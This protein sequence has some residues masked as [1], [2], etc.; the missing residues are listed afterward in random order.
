MQLAGR[1]EEVDVHGLG[2]RPVRRSAHQHRSATAASRRRAAPSASCKDLPWDLVGS[3]TA[4][5]VERAPRAPELLSRGVHE[6][7]ETFDIGNPNLQIE[8]AKTVEAGIRRAARAS[9][10]SRR[11]PTTPAIRGFI[12]RNLTGETCDGTSIPA[13]ARRSS[14]PAAN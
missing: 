6:A 1:I 4:Q 11:P 2:A 9:S 10:A 8:A 5:Y 13:P 14:A 7:T 12:F 3:V